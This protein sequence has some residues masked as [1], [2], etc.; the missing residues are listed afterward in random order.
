[1]AILPQE[2]RFQAEDIRL[3]EVYEIT[4]T[5]VRIANSTDAK[6]WKKLRDQFADVVVVDLRE[7]GPS[8]TMS[9]D[10]LVDWIAAAYAGME[11]FHLV[12]NHDVQIWPGMETGTTGNAEDRAQVTSYGHVLHHQISDGETVHVDCRYEHELARGERGWKVTRFKTT[13]FNRQDDR[14]N[15]RDRG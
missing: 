7:R 5:L 11:T 6:D 8:Q 4:Q 13:P 1:M 9:A 15:R 12:S 14:A 10:E 3:E 2:S